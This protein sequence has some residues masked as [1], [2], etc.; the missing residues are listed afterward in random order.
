[1]NIYFAGAIRGGRVDREWY[2]HIIPIVKK[3][4]KVFTEHEGNIRFNRGGEEMVNIPD[5]EIYSRDLQW[6]SEADAVVSEV[7]TP[8]LG[9]GYELRV[10]EDLG[11]R[12]LCLYREQDNRHL[13]PIIGGNTKFRISPYVTLE[14][15]DKILSE[16][17]SS[18]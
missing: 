6:I 7:T 12:V 5:E 14:D 10:A 9:V 4:G 2:A 13:S 17:F 8:S 11:K 3:Y 16:F 18:S 1:M 15:V